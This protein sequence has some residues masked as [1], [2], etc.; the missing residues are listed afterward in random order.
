MCDLSV[1][2]Y[3]DPDAAGGD[4]PDVS[5]FDDRFGYCMPAFFKIEIDDRIWMRG[6]DHVLPCGFR[7]DP[8]W[9]ASDE[10]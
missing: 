4:S 7:V 9:M 3:G 1:L 6:R 2:G 8:A 5:G 10:G